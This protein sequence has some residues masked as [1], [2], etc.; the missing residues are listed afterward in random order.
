MNPLPGYAVFFDFDNTITKIDILDDIIKRFSIDKKW[1]EFERQWK[2]GGIG[3]RACLKG[4]LA[5]VRLSRIDLLRYLS[6]IKI[7]PY[8][9]KILVLLKSKKIPVKILSDNFSLIINVILR[10]NDICGIK[11]CSN[12]LKFSKNKLLLYFP[13]HNRAC[14]YCAHCKKNNLLKNGLKGRIIYIGD[15]RSDICPA[16]QADIVFAKDDLLKHFKKIRRGCIPFKDLK[17]VYAGLRRMV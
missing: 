1:V 17:S 3:S 15:G 9:K 12:R 5:G 13:H 6:G 14:S 16:Q 4:Q 2:K 11:V 7:D 10:Q 8:F